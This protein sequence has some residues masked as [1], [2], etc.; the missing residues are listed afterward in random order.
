MN[1]FVNYMAEANLGL[2][3]FL[4]TYQLVLRRETNFR[5]SRGYLIVSILVSMISPLFH[6]SIP[7]LLSLG[8]SIP[9]F[10]L[11][12]VTVTSYASS[13]FT[14]GDSLWTSIFVVYF[15]V[16][17]PLLIVF[18]I[19]LLKMIVKIYSSHRIK[20]GSVWVIDLNG[21]REV[22]SFFKFIF[23]GSEITLTAR[24]RE[25][26]INHEMIHVSNYH[27]LDIILINLIGIFFW[28]NPFIKTYRKSLVQLHEF[29]ADA[30][31]VESDEVDEYSSLLAKAA[32][33][34]SGYQ[35]ANH[36]TNSL[37]IKRIKMMKTKKT[38][39]G[40]GKILSVAGIALA[41]CYLIAGN[42]V[43]LAQA[44]TDQQN[45]SEVFDQVDEM[46]TYGKGLDDLYG[47]IAKNMRYPE[48]AK[49]KGIEG[50]V[51]ME[52]VVELDGSLSNVKVTKGI[53]YGCDEE[54]VRVMKAFP[55]WNPG[56]K[57]GKAVRTK[58]VLP[59][60]FNINRG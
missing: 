42:D 55:K 8:K 20:I 57:S 10:W 45:N 30:R 35:L 59:V 12:E 60:L 50:K 34:S 27:S 24:E 53:G 9:A 38:K 47:F 58:M 33:H 43:A 11:P 32:L 21:E 17:L 14:T 25:K 5:F 44:K 54:V 52:F 2:C 13:T 37:T 56:E 18:G 16:V 46:P 22:F 6:F 23:I 36:F 29:E 51:Y 19:R 31:S 3:L 48:E 7:S 26:I 40:T 28:F 4:L 39:I 49:K 41:F 1:T 15:C